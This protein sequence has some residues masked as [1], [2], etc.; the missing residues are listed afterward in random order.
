MNGNEQCFVCVCVRREIVHRITTFFTT[1]MNLCV[2]DRC[3][4]C[5]CVRANDDDNRSN[6]AIT[7]TKKK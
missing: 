5:V 1:F 3:V 4:V 6:S 7:S 2:L